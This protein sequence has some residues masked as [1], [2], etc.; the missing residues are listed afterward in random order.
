[1]NT[2]KGKEKELFNRISEILWKDWDPIGVFSEDDEYKDEYES[3]VPYIYRLAIEGND[4]YKI[5]SKLTMIDVENLGGPNEYKCPQ[6]KHREVARS[7]IKAKKEII[8][9]K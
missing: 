1:M 4:E 6:D 2:L 5:S 9:S 3:Y 7:I 8:D